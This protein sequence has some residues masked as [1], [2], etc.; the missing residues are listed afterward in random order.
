MLGGTGMVRWDDFDAEVYSS[1]RVYLGEQSLILL[2]YT[3]FVFYVVK[4][5]DKTFSTGKILMVT[6]AIL[7]VQAL[8]NLIIGPVDVNAIWLL[9]SMLAVSMIGVDH[10]IAPDDTP[11][12]TKRKVLGWLAI[13]IFIL[14]FSPAPLI[15]L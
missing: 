4:R 10:P 9:Y 15:L 2:L 8:A 13:L 5:L 6:G 12:D 11:L 14:C 1:F 7:F 3:G